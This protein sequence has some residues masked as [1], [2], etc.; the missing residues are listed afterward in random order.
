MKVA[1]AYTTFNDIKMEHLTS[2]SGLR[3]MDVLFPPSAST[4]EEHAHEG[5]ESHLD[6]RNN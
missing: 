2:R 5:K 1:R 4:G 6:K 3:M